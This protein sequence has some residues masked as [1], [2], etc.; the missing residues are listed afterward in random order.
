MRSCPASCSAV[1]RARH[2]GP[3]GEVLVPV[4]LADAA[5]PRGVPVGSARRPGAP[6]RPAPRRQ[7]GT[8]RSRLPQRGGDARPGAGPVA[9]RPGQDPHGS[10]R[11]RRRPRPRRPP[12]R[13]ECYDISTF[14]GRETVGSMVVFEEGRPRSGEYRRFRIRTVEGTNDFASHQE[15]LRRRFRHGRDGRRG[16]EEE[17]RWRLPDLV[18][19]DGGRGQLSAAQE[20]L[21]EAGLG[22]LPCV[23]LAKER[24]ELFVPG[25]SDPV[26]LSVDVPRAV[27][28]P[29]HP[30]RGAPLRDH[31]SPP[32]SA[33]DRRSGAHSTTC[34]VSDP[35]GGAHFFASSGRSSASGR[36][37]SNRSR[38][39]PGSVP[40]SPNGSR[41][42]SK[43]E[44]FVA[45][46]SSFP[47]P[48]RYRRRVPSSVDRSESGRPAQRNAAQM[49]PD[50][51]VRSLRVRR[52]PTGFRV[53]SRL[54][55]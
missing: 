33:R 54:D 35:P 44:R 31:L 32:A 19:I 34:P 55:A 11:S 16:R 40:G 41:R 28:R 22:D 10:R 5:R 7:A 24:E 21:A 15:V 2:L 38:R 1:L 49:H 4:A 12:M 37:R 42:P 29:A 6:P 43:R 51:C 25:R 3:A 8:A 26:V 50:L 46:S 18:I 45:S 47:S 13:I 39:C 53:T 9:R 20:V 48:H 23:G 27:P 17:L 14:Q 52:G 30:R 36:H